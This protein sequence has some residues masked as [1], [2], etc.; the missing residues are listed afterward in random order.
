MLSSVCGLTIEDDI[1]PLRQKRN[2][3][4]LRSSEVSAGKLFL[5]TMQ[6]G[7]QAILSARCTLNPLPLFFPHFS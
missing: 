6:L 1:K 2:N 3:S 7:I 5:A 4:P